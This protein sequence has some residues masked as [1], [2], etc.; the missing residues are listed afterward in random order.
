M[1]NFCKFSDQ[2]FVQFTSVRFQALNKSLTDFNF[3]EQLKCR[4]INCFVNWFLMSRSSARVDKK[5]RILT[6]TLHCSIQFLSLSLRIKL[7]YFI[8]DIQGCKINDLE[9][10]FEILTKINV[11]VIDKKSFL[12][13]SGLE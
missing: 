1:E 5:L 6:A 13:A 10:K 12:T 11:D 7:I 3:F 2:K 4:V 8:C 9:T